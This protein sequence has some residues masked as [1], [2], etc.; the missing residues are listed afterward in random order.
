MYV[1]LVTGCVTPSARQ[2]PRTNV[3]L[4]APS[5][6]ETVT[7]SPGSEDAREPS[8]DGLGLLRRGA[9]S[10]SHRAASSRTGRAGPRA[11]ARCARARHGS[12]CGAARRQP[13][14][15][16][17]RAKSSSSTCSIARRVE[18]GR[19][20]VERVERDPVAAERRPPARLPVDARDPERLAREE[21]RGEVAERRD[22]LSARSARSAEEV[23][24]AGLDLVGLR[25]AVPGRAALDHVRDV[26]V[27]ARRGRSRRAACRA[28][29]RPGRRTG[30]PCLSSWK[31]GASPTNIRSASGSPEPKTTCV[32]PSASRQRVQAETP[33]RTRRAAGSAARGPGREPPPGRSVRPLPD[34]RL[35]AGPVSATE[36]ER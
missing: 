2:A 20:V 6:P 36:L 17:M 24:L 1:G 23:R 7:T 3:V 10:S 29:S 31:P 9:D 12:A 16:G 14:S 22:E 5:S 15:S 19:R 33:A 35:R 28:A 27:R 13:S 32:R 18:R 21:L 30:T 4:P 26:D 11:R 8:G 34:A 25:V